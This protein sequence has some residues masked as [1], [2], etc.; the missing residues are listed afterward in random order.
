MRIFIA[1]LLLASFPASA[2]DI[3]SAT[4]PEALPGHRNLADCEASL[5]AADKTGLRGT[6]FNRLRGNISR[7]EIIQG[8]PQIVVQI[9]GQA[10]KSHSR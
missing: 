3:V 1:V 4:N 8:E 10:K 5:G 6:V 9:K 7:C 2:R